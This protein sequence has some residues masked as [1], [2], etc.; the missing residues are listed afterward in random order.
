[1]SHHP[2]RRELTAESKMLRN[3]KVQSKTQELWPLSP[4]PRGSQD[5]NLPPHDSLCSPSTMRL[6]SIASALA[7]IAAAALTGAM[8]MT[9]LKNR[10]VVAPP[11]TYP[12]EG[13]EWT[14]GEQEHV[15]W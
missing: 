12:T 1:M 2:G 6:S 3:I 9:Q 8:P 7:V 15:D 14:V 10:D 11:I 13:T 5:T 4:S